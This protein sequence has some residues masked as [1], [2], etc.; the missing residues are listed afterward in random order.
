MQAR[1]LILTV[2]EQG[3]FYT[4]IQQ[5][6]DVTPPWGFSFAIVYCIFFSVFRFSAVGFKPQ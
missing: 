1:V 6:K 4:A 5:N 2:D 3:S